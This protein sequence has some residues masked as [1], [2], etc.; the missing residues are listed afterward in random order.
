MA[1]ILVDFLYSVVDKNTCYYY[2]PHANAEKDAI[3][4]AYFYLLNRLF[5]IAHDGQFNIW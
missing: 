3:T 1:F 2:V 4:L 5:I